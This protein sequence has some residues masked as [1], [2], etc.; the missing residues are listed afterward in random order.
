M[1]FSKC[2]SSSYNINFIFIFYSK[3]SNSPQYLI[4]LKF[5][6]P[7]I[8]WSLI[9]NS[10][11]VMTAIL[12]SQ[13]YDWFLN[14]SVFGGALVFVG[15]DSPNFQCSLHLISA[16]LVILNVLQKIM[17]EQARV[18][19]LLSADHK[20]FQPSWARDQAKA[21]SSIVPSSHF[22]LMVTHLLRLHMF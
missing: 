8:S 7:F 10:N 12:L 21:F 22:Y 1:P 6:P 17:D 16:F 4:F 3:H 5:L 19:M 18:T 20:T 13:L 14:S 9:S 2:P 11:N 15:S